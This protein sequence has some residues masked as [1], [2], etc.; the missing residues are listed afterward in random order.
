MNADE[1]LGIGDRNWKIM[2]GAIHYINQ[3]GGF[4]NLDTVME[5]LKET[6]QLEVVGLEFV[7]NYFKV[8]HDPVINIDKENQTS[9]LSRLWLIYLIQ[10]KLVYV[11]INKLID[12]NNELDK[13]LSVIKNQKGYQP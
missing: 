3:S 11:T 13:Y 8:W 7:T 10:S 6:G 1:I 4:V 12:I 2:K 9:I 5:R